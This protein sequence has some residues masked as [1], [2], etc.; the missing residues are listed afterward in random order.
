M[1]VLEKNW[2]VKKKNNPSTGGV[3]DTWTN[4]VIHYN[5][6]SHFHQQSLGDSRFTNDSFVLFEFDIIWLYFLCKKHSAYKK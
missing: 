2:G 6:L 5:D 4:N 1:T 3:A